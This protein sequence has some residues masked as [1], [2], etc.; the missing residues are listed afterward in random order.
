MG[1]VN[2]VELTL[3][4]WDAGQALWTDIR[5]IKKAMYEAV[6]SADRIHLVRRIRE[7]VYSPGDVEICR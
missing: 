6:D 4:G 1:K 3:S 5:E 7:K 2:R